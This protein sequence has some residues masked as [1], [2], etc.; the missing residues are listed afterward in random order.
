M[1]L[2]WVCSIVGVTVLSGA[3]QDLSGI[4]WDLETKGEA[5]QARDRLQKAAEAPGN[6]AALRSYA[7]F[8]D[9][10][11]DPAAREVYAKLASVLKTANAPQSQQAAVARREAILDLLAGDQPAAA[12]HI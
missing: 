8:L 11:R 6:A 2:F 9:R 5:V 12:R 7:E 4:A 3:G 10:H 1:R